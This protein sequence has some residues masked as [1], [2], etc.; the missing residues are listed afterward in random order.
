MAD[1]VNFMIQ[2]NVGAVIISDQKD[3]VGIF[4]EKDFLHKVFLASPPE[5]FFK[6]RVVRQPRI[7]HQIRLQDKI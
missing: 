6:Q 3:P 2:T 4:T 5:C 7:T 1:A